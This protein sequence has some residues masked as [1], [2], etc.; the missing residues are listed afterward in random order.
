M[1]I[2]SPDA[3]ISTKAELAA[4]SGGG[5]YRAVNRAESPFVRLVPMVSAKA[6]SVSCMQDYEDEFLLLDPEPLAEEFP[7]AA[8]YRVAENLVLRPAF[9]PRASEMPNTMR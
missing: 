8:Y 9:L 2:A 5:D 6:C 1:K 7:E 3:V 4:W